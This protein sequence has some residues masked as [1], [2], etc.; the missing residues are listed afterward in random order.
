[1]SWNDDDR[2]MPLEADIEAFGGDEAEEL[3]CPACGA[4]VVE[5]TPK[6]PHCG[7]WITPIEAG[8]AFSKRWW[9]VV[10]ILLM[11]LAMW[12]FVF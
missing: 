7:E 1:L 6:C 12:R 4:M 8:G 5:D 9:L 10:A 3:S 11:L 2:D